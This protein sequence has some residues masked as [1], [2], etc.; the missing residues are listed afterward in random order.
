MKR[1]LIIYYTQVP[2]TPDVIDNEAFLL[3]RIVALTKARAKFAVFLVGECIG[4]FS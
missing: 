1:W 3:Y 2:R 4:D